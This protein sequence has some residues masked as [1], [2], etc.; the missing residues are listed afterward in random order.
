MYFI[1][2]LYIIIYIRY[3]KYVQ[4]NE[5]ILN[6]IVILLDLGGE[7]AKKIYGFPSKHICKDYLLKYKSTFTSTRRGA[8]GK[9]M[10]QNIR[11]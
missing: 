9:F 10:S 8:S 7:I 11:S 3:S 1:V 5:Q 4:E 2:I 6:A